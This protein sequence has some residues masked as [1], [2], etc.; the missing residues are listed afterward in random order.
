MAVHAAPRRQLAFLVEMVLAEDACPLGFAVA[1]PPA[2]GLTGQVGR[3]GPPPNGDT[4]G[5]KAHIDPQI[6]L[7]YL[8]T[9]TPAG[10]VRRGGFP[11]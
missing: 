6:A 1:Q 10:A 11:I 8:R 3:H 2:R 4:E 9:V 7:D 5:E